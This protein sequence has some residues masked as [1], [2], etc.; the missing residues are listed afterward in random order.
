MF[1]SGLNRYRNGIRL[2]VI[3]F[4]I[5]LCI[6]M[7]YYSHFIIHKGIVFT[8]FFYL[9]IVLAAYWWGKKA[10]CVSLFLS[11][12]L[13]ISYFFSV[14][15][16]S[17]INNVIRAG[18][19]ITVGLVTGILREQSIKTEQRLR[20]TGEYLNSL[21]RSA[22]GPI[23]VLNKQGRIT[24]FNP[25][26]EHL[27]GYD[28][29]KILGK[30]MEVFIPEDS[31]KEI[32][33]KI[34]NIT[35]DPE[36]NA[37]ELPIRRKDGRTAVCLWN[38][39][40]IYETDGKSPIAT[41]IQGQDITEHKKAEEMLK[42]SHFELAQILETAA[43]GIWIID[44]DFKVIRTNDTLTRMAELHKK[45]I[46]GKKCFDVFG[47]E[48]CF[49]KNCPLVMILSGESFVE[50]ETEKKRTGGSKIMCMLT[51]RPY[52]NPDGEL[53]GI[54]EDLRDISELKQLNGELEAAKLYAEN[55][56]SNFLDTL[57]VTNPDGTISTINQAALDLL[58]YE[59]EEL[60]GKPVGTIFEKGKEVKP[61]FTGTLKE[62]ANRGVLRNYELTY[63]TRSGRR[64]PMSFN[65]SVMRNENGK[66]L[67]L[68]A[69]AKDISKLKKTEARL[70]QS[71]K[72]EAIG[73]LAGGVAH[74]FNNMLT[75]ILGY[76]DFCM[77]VIEE[78]NAAYQ[79]LNEILKAAKRAANLTNQLLLF[80]RRQPMKLAPIDINS[81]ILDM[82]KM[83]N[84][85]IGEDISLNTTL[86]PKLRNIKADIGNIE[87]LI[88]NLAV[89][90]R[91]AMPDGGKICI[92]TK[93]VLVDKEYCRTYKYARPGR[94]ICLTIRD[95]G[96]GMDHAILERIFEPFFTTKGIGKGTG[97]GLS[98][99][100][101]IVKKHDG[102]INVETSP[103]KGAEF[104]IFLP[105]I[106]RKIEEKG[107][108][109]VSPKV[110]K[111]SGE[112]IL[113]VEDNDD[114][115]NLSVKLLSGNGYEVFAAANVRKAMDIFDKR[116]GDFDLI[117]CDVILP[118]GRGPKLV[119]KF[120]AARPGLRILMT[121]GYSDQKSDWQT[122]RERGYNFLQKPYSLSDLLNAVKEI[123][124]QK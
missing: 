61:F 19:F 58:E 60:I 121:S 2:T 81:V 7:V 77:T 80:S 13:L 9:P 94:F 31:Q 70:R 24:L 95:S 100:Y 15:N 110:L 50:C 10:V 64:I 123:L 90:A 25:A 116:D 75:V 97:M 46:L 26:I 41:I 12:L 38:S 63:V 74:D 119:D 88:I 124:K 54:V 28:E 30:S 59:E 29:D 103:G 85:L 35:G 89:N 68:V 47:G 76:I 120:V 18:M 65:A 23:I 22:S 111:G 8:H 112:R 102:W 17:F 84:R 36:W 105:V 48:L 53:I 16:I 118:D 108:G 96:G 40:T 49:T 32:L 5:L 98:V 92:R 104:R 86:E 45:E 56:I 4:L 37:I 99:V 107:R 73:Q 33:Q 43:D 115:R 83:L 51:S 39:A 114:I 20:E 44:R 82:S 21:I 6:V 62:L 87:Q 14:L 27:T 79:Y 55:I 106:S 3:T 1:S 117:F 122:I 113:L 67:G 57:I 72:M 109:T 34:G 42:R 93:N 101:G 66:I 91:D 69:G 78:D 52:Q 11:V 71:Q